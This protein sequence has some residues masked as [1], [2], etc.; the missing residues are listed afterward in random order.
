MLG[1]KLVYRGDGDLVVEFAKGSGQHQ[2]T[3]LLFLGSYLG[4]YLA[5]LLDKSHALVQD[6]PD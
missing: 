3:F 5:A 1:H 2:G 4:S 6:L